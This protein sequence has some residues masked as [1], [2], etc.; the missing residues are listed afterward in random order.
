MS[1]PHDTKHDNEELTR[2]VLGLLSE[3]DS[4]RLDDASIT[5]DEVAARLRTME[6]DLVDSYIRGQLAGETLER[7][8]SHYLSSPHR[9]D[10]VRSARTFIRAVDRSVARADGVAP[11]DRVT[12]PFGRAQMVAASPIVVVSTILLFQAMRPSELS[13]SGPGGR[14]VERPTP[15][16]GQQLQPGP[17]AT[18]SPAFTP[19]DV[20]RAASRGGLVAVALDPP[21][22]AA[23]PAPTLA[24]P[25][26]VDRVSFAL[27]LESNDFRRY[28]V[29]LTD[30]ATG[31]ALWRSDWIS[32]T[33][34]A[35]DASVSVVVPANL[36][37]MRHYS[38]DLSGRG[39]DGRADVVG[40]YIVRIDP[41]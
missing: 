12:W 26:D 40:S 27:R 17:A 19:P 8:E 7:F 36:F 6:S 29:T 23:T 16:V 18:A 34:S 38:L 1:Q 39:A 13:F 3:E 41:P 5:D 11:K 30:P 4:E 37:S 33:S 25:A 2:Y 9:R 28:R 20:P 15:E 32:P 22:R 24:I 14:G 21:T 31:Q 35:D 10:S